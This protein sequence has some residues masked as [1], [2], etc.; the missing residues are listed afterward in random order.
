M[1]RR[2]PRSTLFPYTTLFRSQVGRFLIFLQ[3]ASGRG[4]DLLL[5]FVDHQSPFWPIFLA[6][7]SAHLDSRLLVP[8]DWA[9]FIPL[10]L[11]IRLRCAS[12][13]LSLSSFYPTYNMQTF[14]LFLPLEDDTT[15]I[16]DPAV[17]AHPHFLGCLS[18]S[19][20][21]S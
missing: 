21:Q 6:F 11:L 13:V 1:I 12:A 7:T 5:L 8:S 17:S 9:S 19:N 14:H 15:V 20:S 2:P 10:V 4:L 18:P 16:D 3:I